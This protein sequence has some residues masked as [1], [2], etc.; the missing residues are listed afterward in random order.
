VK[1][2]AVVLTLA[3][4]A[5]ERMRGLLAPLL[6]TP[7]ADTRVSLLT[8][9]SREDEDEDEGADEGDDKRARLHHHHRAVAAM[10]DDRAEHFARFGLFKLTPRQIDIVLSLRI[11]HHGV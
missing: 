10:D 2:A 8:S 11:D 1:E 5:R 9:R 7:A 6:A 4:E 3:T